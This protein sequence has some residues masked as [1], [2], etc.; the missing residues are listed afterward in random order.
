MTPVMMQGDPKSRQGY[1]IKI[2]T[3]FIM[4]H[5]IAGQTDFRRG[6]PAGRPYR[7]PMILYDPNVR[8]DAIALKSRQIKALIRAGVGV[9]D[10][11]CPPRACTTTPPQAI[12]TA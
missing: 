2:L 10:S 5:K 12:M 11:A 8:F 1:R 6:D 4:V 3:G 7:Y 9:P